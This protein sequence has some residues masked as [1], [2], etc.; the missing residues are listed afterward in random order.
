MAGEELK[1]TERGWR[2]IVTICGFH[3]SLSEHCVRITS[4]RL[5]F[6]GHMRALPLIRVAVVED[7]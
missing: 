6:G 5:G 1:G 2:P 4:K 7:T 3:T